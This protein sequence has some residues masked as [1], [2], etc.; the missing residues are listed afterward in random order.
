[1]SSRISKKV[2]AKAKRDMVRRRLTR[3]KDGNTDKCSMVYNFHE[4]SLVEVRRFFSLWGN[5][6]YIDINKG[7]I[8]MVVRG[9]YVHPNGDGIDILISG[10]LYTHVNPK[11][12][13]AYENE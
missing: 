7:T 10:D 12:L 6:Q 11:Y 4:G 9:P 2:L 8:A 5:H 13:V 3:A 1:M